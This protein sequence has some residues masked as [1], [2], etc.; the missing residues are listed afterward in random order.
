MFDSDEAARHLLHKN[1]DVYRTDKKGRNGLHYIRSLNSLSVVVEERP[2]VLQGLQKEESIL[3]TLALRILRRSTVG[4]AQKL[5]G[6]LTQPQKEVL[7]GVLSCSN[8]TSSLALYLD[9]NKDNNTAVEGTAFAMQA[10]FCGCVDALS[11]IVS[12]CSLDELRSASGSTIAHYAAAGDCSPSQFSDILRLMKTHP[13]QIAAVANSDGLT[14]LHCALAAGNFSVARM[15]W[16]SLRFDSG[17]KWSPS[18]EEA[19]MLLA[20]SLHPSVGAS[21]DDALEA[22]LEPLPSSQPRSVAAEPDVLRDD[23]EDRSDVDIADDDDLHDEDDD[24]ASDTS[25]NRGQEKTAAVQQSSSVP[26]VIEEDGNFDDDDD[27]IDFDDE[28]FERSAREAEDSGSVVRYDDDDGGD[29]MSVHPV[30]KLPPR[31]EGLTFANEICDALNCAI[32]PSSTRSWSPLHIACR[33]KDPLVV[34]YLLSRSLPLAAA[35]IPPCWNPLHESVAA[36]DAEIVF[37]LLEHG[38]SPFARDASTGYTPLHVACALDS[39]VALR[40]ICET[41]I[42]KDDDIA[43]LHQ[44]CMDRTAL[45]HNFV[46]VAVIGHSTESLSTLLRFLVDTAFD[47]HRLCEL[48]TAYDSVGLSPMHLAALLGHSDIG[49]LIKQYLMDHN[50]NDSS[51]SVSEVVNAPDAAFGIRP[52]DYANSQAHAR[53]FV[54][55]VL[56]A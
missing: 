52:A 12:S 21:E 51:V 8:A 10:A 4:G 17:S 56:S 33:L 39:S 6:F 48:L 41:T 16:D 49:M 20:A 50:P 3:P 24:V 40:V 32:D 37:R 18:S 34:D 31:G 26:A 14:P 1:V 38:F 5:M 27:D 55:R 42:L 44:C 53:D 47:P 19:Y 43:R 22:A 25:F 46:H 54:Q 2:D 36:D 13:Y 30:Q 7:A 15:L 28:N 35:M 29:T 45:G 11:A 23:F 9:A